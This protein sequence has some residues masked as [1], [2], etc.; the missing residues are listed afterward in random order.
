[1]PEQAR[2]TCPNTTNDAADAGPRGRLTATLASAGRCLRHILGGCARAHRTAVQAPV[3]ADLHLRAA[4]VAA[5]A[6]VG[7]GDPRGRQLLAGR[8]RVEW[9]ELGE[10]YDG[11]YD[12]E[13][14]DDVELLRFYFSGL[15]DGHWLE[16]SGTSYCTHVPASTDPATRQ[17]L[18][19]ILAIEGA[20]AIEAGLDARLAANGGNEPAAA[21]EGELHPAGGRRIYQQLSWIAPDWA[22]LPGIAA[23]TPSW[24][25]PAR[26]PPN[27]RRRHRMDPTIKTTDEAPDAATSI[28]QPEPTTVRG[29]LLALAER[30]ANRIV[31]HELPVRW[32]LVVVLVALIL[33]GLAARA[34]ADTLKVTHLHWSAE[35]GAFLLTATATAP[36]DSDYAV[37]VTHTSC[38]TAPNEQDAFHEVTPQPSQLLANPPANPKGVL[39]VCVWIL[40]EDGA[41]GARYDHAT[42]IPRRTVR[43]RPRK[44]ARRRHTRQHRCD[45]ATRG[46][47]GRPDALSAA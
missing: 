33:V 10:G 1:M 28:E 4:L 2:T 9:A 3:N 18:L 41:I 38:P 12:P 27:D 16:V 13:D 8:V 42:R 39:H 14:P 44:P 40:H 22:P 5:L 17:Q 19:A 35:S 24:G 26:R 43:H 23:N 30:M 31:E 47:A 36:A 34:N 29:R 11:D 46:L 45:K 25:P 37:A 6:N 32:Q 21:R 7:E 15:L 20:P